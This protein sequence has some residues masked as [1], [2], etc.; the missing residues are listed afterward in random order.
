MND[1]PLI[2][3]DSF[4][5]MYTFP[6]FDQIEVG[7]NLKQFVLDLHSGK[8]HREFHNGPDPTV[9]PVIKLN[10]KKRRFNNNYLF[11]CLN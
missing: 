2:A 11:Y 9:K 6:I 4:R 3:I 10:K 8:L 5:H 7:N 1:L